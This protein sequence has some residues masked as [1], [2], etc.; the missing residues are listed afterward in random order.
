[1][2]PASPG[3]LQITCVRSK[4]ASGMLLLFCLKKYSIHQRSENSARK[5]QPKFEGFRTAFVGLAAGKAQVGV[6]H[7]EP[8]SIRTEIEGSRRSVA[9]TS[10]DFFGEA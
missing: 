2:T 7:R 10:N 6:G 5:G 3:K 4:I 1:M 9:P 8:D